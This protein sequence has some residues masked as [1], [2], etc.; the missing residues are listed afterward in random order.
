MGVVVLDGLIKLPRWL[1]PVCVCL[2]VCVLELF[3]F[4][5]LEFRANAIITL[6]TV[7]ASGKFFGTPSEGQ[8]QRIQKDYLTYRLPQ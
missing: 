1:G 6:K 7:Q 8:R 2:F 4:S 3:A 5:G